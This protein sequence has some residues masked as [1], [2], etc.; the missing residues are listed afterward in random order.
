MRLRFRSSTTLAEQ[1]LRSPCRNHDL[2]IAHERGESALD[3]HGCLREI[4]ESSG[5]DVVRVDPDAF[6]GLDPRG[7]RSRGPTVDLG[8]SV[9]LRRFHVAFLAGGQPYLDERRHDAENTGA[10][11]PALGPSR[12]D[13]AEQDRS[14]LLE[15]ERRIIENGQNRLRLVGLKRERDDAPLVGITELCCELFVLQEVCELEHERRREGDA[16][17]EHDLDA[18]GSKGALWGR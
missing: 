15:P 9:A 17:Q 5:D 11:L 6:H 1:T 16:R 14:E 18:T 8:S 7:L 12:R 3:R 4:D 13:L 10:W 2:T